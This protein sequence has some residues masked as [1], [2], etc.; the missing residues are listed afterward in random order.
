MTTTEAE[1]INEQY[2]RR[3][4]EIA[5]FEDKDEPFNNTTTGK[6]IPYI[7]WFWRDTDFAGK[8]ILIGTTGDYVGVMENNKWGYPDRLMT[9]EEA[10]TFIGYLDRA[11]AASEQAQAE[12]VYAELRRWFQTLKI[13]EG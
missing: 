3:V 1:Q 2:N 12:T 4:A 11:F 7:G 8:R 13:E 10:T 5:D 6:R 9:E